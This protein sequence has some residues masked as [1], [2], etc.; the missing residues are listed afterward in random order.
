MEAGADFEEGADAPMNLRPAGSGARDARQDLQ[1]RRFARAVAADEAKHF[2]FFHFQGNIFQGP[3]GFFLFSAQRRDGRA[4]KRFERV[5]K[6][7][8]HLQATMI[9]LAE[10]FSMNDGIHRLNVP[11]F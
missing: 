4:E 10:P 8:V 9:A 2:A 6:P 7:V 1:Q 3:E 5:A 11:T